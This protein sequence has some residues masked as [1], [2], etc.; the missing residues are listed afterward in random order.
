MND[1]L[2]SFGGFVDSLLLLALFVA[3]VSALLHLRNYARTHE[4]GRGWQLLRDAAR[5][6]ILA[7]EQ[8][9]VGSGSEKKTYVS[10][11]LTET[12]VTHDIPI[13]ASQLDALIE[14]VLLE[15]KREST[16]RLLGEMLQNG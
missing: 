10:A 12:A 14:G 13:S 1:F 9:E 2:Q 7:A 16:R 15:I 11:L 8:K 3:V 6:Y 4:A 5:V